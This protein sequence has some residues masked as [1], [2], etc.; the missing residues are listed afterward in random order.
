MTKLIAQEQCLLANTEGSTVSSNI[1]KYSEI[2]YELEE[3]FKVVDAL[4]KT[5][6]MPH[7]HQLLAYIAQSLTIL[8]Q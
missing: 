6:S 3:L 1:Y 5:L 2:N 7:I 8:A 4:F